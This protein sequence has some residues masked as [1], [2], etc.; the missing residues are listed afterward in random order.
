MSLLT[1]DEVAAIDPHTREPFYWRGWMDDVRCHD[2]ESF[3]LRGDPLVTFK[4]ALVARVCGRE[5]APFKLI[6]RYV[7]L[8][9]YRTSDGGYVCHRKWVSEAHAEPPVK[10]DVVRAES[11]TDMRDS[12]LNYDPTALA[13]TLWPEDEPETARR[14]RRAKAWLRS[15]YAERVE[16]LTSIALLIDYERGTA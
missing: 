1:K 10:Y 3:L 4:G 9:L 13:Y 15:S 11:I 6:P 14:S 2:G 16:R 12:L 7:D 8:T 5:R